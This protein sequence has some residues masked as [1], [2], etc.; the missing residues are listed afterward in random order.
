M[1]PE[2]QTE[3]KANLLSRLQWACR[4]GMLE[5]DVLLGDFLNAV[6]SSLSRQQQAKFEQLLTF[7][8]PEIYDWIMGHAIPDDHELAIMAEQI[9]QHARRSRI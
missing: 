4:R 5:L 1:L 2:N 7:S 3:M 9:R 8:D 6:Y